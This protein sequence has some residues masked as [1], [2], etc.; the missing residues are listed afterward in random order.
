M[1]LLSLLTIPL[2]L[3]S[4]SLASCSSNLP[5]PT[6]APMQVTAAVSTAT[7]IT[8]TNTALPQDPPAAS[9]TPSPTAL[10]PTESSISIPGGIVYYYF[11]DLAQ[12]APPSGSVV[13]MPD[14]LVLAPA[15]LNAIYGSDVTADLRTGLE[16]VLKDERNDW[17]SDKLQV[18]QIS[19]SEGHVNLVLEGEYYAVAPVVL[20]A[21]RAQILMTLFANAAVQSATVMINESNIANISISHSMDAKPDDYAYTRAEIEAYMAENA[22]L[23]P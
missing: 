14:T 19:F 2:L 22:Y 10:L 5:A 13:V 9:D 11:V 1:K 18:Q 17:L 8:E 4:V 15:Q 3:A 12:Y 7:V 16:S 6:T 23:Q 21:A 20:T